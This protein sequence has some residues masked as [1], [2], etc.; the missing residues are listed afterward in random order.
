LNAKPN[1]P[2]SV[3]QK[4]PST[5]RQRRNAIIAI[6]C[7][8]I[9]QVIG[10]LLIKQGSKELAENATMIETAIG[11]ITIPYLFAGYACYGLFTV[12]MVLALKHAELSLLYP[13]MSMTYVWLPLISVLWL[14]E[15]INMTIIAGIM[16]ITA[17]IAVLGKGEKLA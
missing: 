4:P 10:Q 13:I 8:A 11:M 1:S 9:I 2:D 17:G 3:S 16:V 6:A 7:A 5:P 15:P 12:I 14:G